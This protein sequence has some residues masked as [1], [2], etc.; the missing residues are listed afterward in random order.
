MDTGL[1]EQVSG[2]VKN[3]Q[4]Q[5]FESKAVGLYTTL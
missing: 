4:D 2:G 3:F 1:I 5:Q